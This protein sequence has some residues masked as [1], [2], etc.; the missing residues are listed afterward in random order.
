MLC[1]VVFFRGGNGLDWF[2]SIRCASLEEARPS[3]PQ[4]EEKS[5]THPIT[6]NN[7]TTTREQGSQTSTGYPGL[8]LHI[9]IIYSRGACWI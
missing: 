4:Q 5:S 8:E 7:E 6:R 2:S 1:F 9:Y 3:P